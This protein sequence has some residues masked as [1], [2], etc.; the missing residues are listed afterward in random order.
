[1]FK[2]SSYLK[3]GGYGMNQVLE[4]SFLFHRMAISNA[5]FANIPKNLVYVRANNDQMAR[6]LGI[7][8]FEVEF[9]LLLSMLNSGYIN[10]YNFIVSL[11][12]RFIFRCSPIFLLKFFNK[13]FF[14]SKL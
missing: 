8:Y 5:K 6:R 4:D 12:I 13:Y 3:S 11:I 9:S 7:K 14:R 1:M 2:K 10:F